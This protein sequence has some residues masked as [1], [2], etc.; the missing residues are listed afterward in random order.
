MTVMLLL[1][2]N[3]I[4][5]KLL[6]WEKMIRAILAFTLIPQPGVFPSLLWK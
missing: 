6:G 2:F 1:S 4:D 3:D 5:F